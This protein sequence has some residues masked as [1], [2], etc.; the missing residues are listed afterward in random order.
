MTIEET[1]ARYIRRLADDMGLK[2]WRFDVRVTD[3]HPKNDSI[4]E[5]DDK[6]FAIDATCE[7]IIGQR[8]ATITIG[9]DVK[10]IEVEVIRHTIVHELVHCHM[11]DFYEHGRKGILD[12][13]HQTVYDAWMYGFSLTWEHTVDAI[14]VAWSEKLPCIKWPKEVDN[15]TS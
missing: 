11:A 10:E 9:T 2:D 6:R 15:A 14:A 1:L 5:E 4:V 13:V 7:P 8:K 3:D 12:L